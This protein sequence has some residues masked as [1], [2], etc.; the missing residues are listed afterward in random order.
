MAAG[1]NIKRMKCVRHY[2]STQRSVSRRQLTERSERNS[3][4]YSVDR[5]GSKPAFTDNDDHRSVLH[6][7][8]FGRNKNWSTNSFCCTGP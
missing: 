3:N 7:D 8:L 5:N 6:E 2:S 4:A 1:T